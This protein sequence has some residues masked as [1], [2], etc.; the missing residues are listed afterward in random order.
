MCSLRKALRLAGQQM[1]EWPRKPLF[2]LALALNLNFTLEPAVALIRASQLLGEPLQVLEPYLQMSSSSKTCFLWMIG[3]VIFLS[4]APFLDER[5]TYVGLRMGR[6]EWL[7]AQL[8][9]V[10]AA[11]LLYALVRLLFAFALAIPFSY[12]GNLWSSTLWAIANDEGD[13]A[14]Q[15]NIS[16]PNRYM[17]TLYTPCAFLGLSLG[18]QCLYCLTIGMMVFALNLVS[19]KGVGIAVALCVH[20]LGYFIACDG[21][22]FANQRWSLL[23]HSLACFHDFSHLVIRSYPAFRESFALFLGLIGGLAALCAAWAHRIDFSVP[24]RNL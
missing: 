21:I 12:S 8:L 19:R 9:Y 10:A 1:G 22:I 14:S 7:L 24:Y 17:L 5:A 15:L 2:W 13:I 23:V 16:F 20:N 3:L 4:D 6:G 18:L 11:C